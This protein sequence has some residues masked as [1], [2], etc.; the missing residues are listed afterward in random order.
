MEKDNEMEVDTQFVC[1]KCGRA[2]P[3]QEEIAIHLKLIHNACV[4]AD[5]RNISDLNMHSSVCPYRGFDCIVCH[6]KFNDKNLLLTH[7]NQ[8]IDVAFFICEIC[9]EGFQLRK[10]LQ[11]HVLEIHDK[12]TFLPAIPARSK[13]MYQKCPHCEKYFKLLSEFEEHKSLC[14]S[15]MSVCDICKISF[16]SLHLLENHQ[17][18]EHRTGQ[19]VTGHQAL[20]GGKR[21]FCGICYLGFFTGNILEEHMKTHEA[22]ASY[23]CDVCHSSFNC[24]EDL[25]EHYLLHI[26][27]HYVLHDVI[28]Q[29]SC[30]CCKRMFKSQQ[31]LENH[32][33]LG[34]CS[35]RVKDK[36][37]NRF[38]KSNVT[39]SFMEGIS[40]FSTAKENSELHSKNINISQNE[41]ESEIDNPDID[42]SDVPVYILKSGVE[43]LNCDDGNCVVV[44]DHKSVF[45]LQRGVC[46]SEDRMPDL[47]NIEAYQ[48]DD[49][50]DAS[51][52]K[53]HML[54]VLFP[55]EE[56]VASNGDN[57][58]TDM[59]AESEMTAP[60]ETLDTS[61]T[62]NGTM[63]NDMV[64][65]I[66]YASVL[67]A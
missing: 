36:S 49:D 5:C 6:K 37:S 18:I 19:P 40:D 15:P 64:Q 45:V 1:Y 50:I 7:F 51:L 13:A 28:Q 22:S 26:E 54:R 44:I 46:A 30:G 2:F 33:L 66:I 31:L 25:Q 41:I 20:K 39:K 17:R 23:K 16:L 59:N 58:E 48:E 63:D 55:P 21:Y 60:I 67:R 4:T 11:R 9:R 42:V 14:N 43:L 52:L 34:I 38:C 3:S 32:L 61:D 56:N 29:H 65:E 10:S 27:E 24:D 8:H 35:K 47:S 53:N 62:D 12:N 57:S